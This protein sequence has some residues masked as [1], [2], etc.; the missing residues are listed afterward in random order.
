MRSERGSTLPLVLGFF[1]LA[2][3]MVAGS[4]ALGEAFVQQRDLQATCD[5]AAAAAAASGADLDR[6][7]GVGSG[8]SLR[9][10]DVR[11]VV[12]RYLGRDPSRRQVRV[13]ARLSADGTRVSLTCRERTSLVLGGLFGRGHVDHLATS[14]ARAAVLG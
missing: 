13:T 14:T 2:L 3:L 12:A 6:A 9:F 10:G 8:E 5:G 4:V 1:V 11:L 7:R